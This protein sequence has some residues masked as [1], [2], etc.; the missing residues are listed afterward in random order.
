VDL[1]QV[2]RRHDDRDLPVAA[3]GAVDVAIG[4]YH[5]MARLVDG[6]MRL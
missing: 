3:F 4:V 1:A 2:A 5:F 6:E